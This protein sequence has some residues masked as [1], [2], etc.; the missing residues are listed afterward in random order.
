MRI[1]RYYDSWLA[2]IPCLLVT[3]TILN[4]P[5]PADCRWHQF[6]I[7][8]VWQEMVSRA[9][10]YRCLNCFCLWLFPDNEYKWIEKCRW[11]W[12]AGGEID[13]TVARH[14][15]AETEMEWR[16]LRLWGK[17]APPSTTPLCS[18]CLDYGMTEYSSLDLRSPLC[19]GDVSW[20]FSTLF[21]LV[22]AQLFFLNKTL[23]IWIIDKL[24]G[25]PELNDSVIN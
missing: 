17:P 21:H 10:Y 24:E 9:L 11:T 15:H 2:A 7:K 13:S 19:P 5:F 23:E 22:P 14:L 6:R 25:R 8:T 3:T 1:T 20:N 4:I 18:R 16:R 12:T